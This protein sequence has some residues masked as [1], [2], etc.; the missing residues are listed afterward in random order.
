MVWDKGTWTPHGDW[1]AGWKAGK[2]NFALKGKKLKGS[3]TL[4]R[5]KGAK[6]GVPRRWLLIKSPDE[7]ARKSS[8]FDIIAAKPDS[9]KTGRSMEEIKAARKRTVKRASLRQEK[10]RA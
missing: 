10:K 7:E 4:V 6:G 5:F 3:W 8:R 9:V 2:L 1:K